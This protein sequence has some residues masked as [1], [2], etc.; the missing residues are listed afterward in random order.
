MNFKDS[1]FIEVH[2]NYVRVLIAHAVKT[3]NV[4][5]FNIESE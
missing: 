1:T 2:G 3:A 4:Y 5:D